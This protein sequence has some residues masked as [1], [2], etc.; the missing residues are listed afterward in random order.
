MEITDP[1]VQVKKSVATFK[2]L[3]CD[4]IFVRYIHRA[5]VTNL[6]CLETNLS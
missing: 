4:L 1:R 5:K 3:R 6:I 2:P